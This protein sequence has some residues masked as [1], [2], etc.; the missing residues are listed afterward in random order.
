M[1]DVIIIFNSMPI[2]FPHG[3]SLR[4][5]LGFIHNLGMGYVPYTPPAVLLLSFINTHIPHRK[6]KDTHSS[7]A[8]TD[9]HHRV[10][11]ELQRMGI[12]AKVFETL[13]QRARWHSASRA[14]DRN[15]YCFQMDAHLNSAWCIAQAIARIFSRDGYDLCAMH[16]TGGSYPKLFVI[17][18]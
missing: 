2:F 3:S 14:F 7:M 5:F 11:Q 6:K 17:F 9:L 4:P 16:P 18:Y 10:A 8:R 12:E 15:C 13:E 1:D